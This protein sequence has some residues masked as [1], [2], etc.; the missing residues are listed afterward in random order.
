MRKYYI[1]TVKKY[2]VYTP[3]ATANH[4]RFYCVEIILVL[5]FNTN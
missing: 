1:R 3:T 5:D 2:K 4:V